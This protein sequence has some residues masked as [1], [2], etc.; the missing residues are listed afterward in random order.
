MNNAIVQIDRAIQQSAALVE[1]NASLAEYLG[2]VAHTL[3]QLGD[4]FELGSCAEH[5]PTAIM[6]RR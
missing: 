6:I 1:E 3:D 5:T 2:D 4:Q